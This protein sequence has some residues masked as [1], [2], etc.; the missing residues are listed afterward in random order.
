TRLLR[1]VR[2]RF[3]ID[4]DDVKGNEGLGIGHFG[5]VFKAQYKNMPVAVKVLN[6]RTVDNR[7]E[8]NN[9]IREALMLSKYDHKNIVKFIGIAAMKDPIM[10][11]MELVEK[12]SLSNYLEN[13]QNDPSRNQLIKFCRD[14]AR[15]MA[16]LE[17]RNVIH[18]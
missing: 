8:K 6:E 18:R 9:F 17:E 2:R 3:I 16:Y 5:Q 13:P 11:V 1:P 12:G 15:G 4:N 10:I 7:K 14:I